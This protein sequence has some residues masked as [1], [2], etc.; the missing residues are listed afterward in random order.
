MI[1]CNA[2]IEDFFYCGECEFRA[3]RKKD[4]NIHIRKH[5][6]DLFHCPECE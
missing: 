2:Q 6:N 4:L 5:T 3:K 1:Y